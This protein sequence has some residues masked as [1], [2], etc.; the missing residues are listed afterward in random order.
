MCKSCGLGEPEITFYASNKTRCKECVR[1]NTI[2]NR[3]AKV[4]YYRAY[5]RMRS[6]VPQQVHKEARE[7][8]REAA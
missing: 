7:M 3:L 4:D 8:E 2:A 1:A 6:S 5:D